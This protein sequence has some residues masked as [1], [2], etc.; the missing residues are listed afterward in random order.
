MQVWGDPF[1]GSPR[2]AS[3]WR[4]KEE[5]HAVIEP[6]SYG[7][8]SYL[9]QQEFD[10]TSLSLDLRDDV[11]HLIFPSGEKRPLT[12]LGFESLCRVIQVPLAFAKRLRKDGRCEVLSYLQKQ[13]SSAYLKEPAVVVCDSST[14]RDTS[15]H[16]LS[17]TTKACI[18][19]SLHDVCAMDKEIVSVAEKFSKAELKVRM[20]DGTSLRYGFMTKRAKPM[21]DSSEYEF[22][23]VFCYSLYGYEMPHI[24]Q[25]ALRC[26]DM[27]LLVLP[28]KPEYYD[29]SSTT[30]LGDLGSAIEHLD[31]AGWVE[32]ESYLQRMHGVK[33]S[34]RE[35]KET[36][37]R[38]AKTLKVDKEDKETEKRLEEFFGWKKLVERYEIKE[39]S[40]KPSKRWYMSAQSHL[41]LLDVFIKLVSETTHAPSTLDNLKRTKLEKYATRILGRMPDLAE[42]SP[43][44]LVF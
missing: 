37:Q 13:L 28:F 14:T 12:D 27:S 22:G 26:D 32:L 11:L 6:R 31:S 3:S 20:E 18:L 33:A 35:V 40:P 23:H 8:Y 4:I 16:V 29:A 30:F 36:K 10:L 43:P 1:V 19:K 24:Y 2:Y 7:K 38:L 25:I 15:N 5:K 44:K 41:S 34:L 42:K 21:A 39:L 9:T 17:V